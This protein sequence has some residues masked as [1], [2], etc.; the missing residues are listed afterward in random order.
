MH[1]SSAASRV[2]QVWVR[3]RDSG[4]LAA[5]APVSVYVLGAGERPPRVQ[6]PPADLFLPE[7]SP[8]GTLIT[9]LRAPD[10]L[11]TTDD[12]SSGVR[13]RLAGAL[14]PRDLFAVEGDR[15]VLSGQLDRETAS[16]HIIG[17]D[18]I[19]IETRTLSERS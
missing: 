12:S 14:W 8:P 13:Y 5:E 15:L 19:P 2:V 9:E 6:P 3:A 1:W 7:D 4:G 17:Q 11:E 10:T 18:I 16:E